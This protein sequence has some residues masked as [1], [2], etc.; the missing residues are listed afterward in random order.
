VGSAPGQ[1]ALPRPQPALST[2]GQ[3]AGPR[4][5]R[6]DVKARGDAAVLSFIKTATG[7]KAQA[8]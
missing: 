2:R 5:D 3:A 8:G 1:L 4:V 6:A 7:T